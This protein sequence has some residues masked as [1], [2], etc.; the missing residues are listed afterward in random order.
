MTPAGTRW[1]R[2]TPVQASQA[3]T[4]STSDWCSAT[5]TRARRRIWT[6]VSTRRS[7]PIARDSPAGL[8][9]RLVSGVDPL[10]P[11][12]CERAVGSA[13][14]DD[15]RLER[16]A[17][18]ITEVAALEHLAREPALELLDHRRPTRSRFPL[19]AR[20]LVHLVAGL[21][22]EQ[23]GELLGIPR[24]RM[25]H[26]HVG[27]H[28]QPVR[29]VLHRQAGQEARR[30]DRDLGREADQ[31]SRPFVSASDR[32]DEQRVVE[33]AD[34]PGEV[35]IERFHRADAT[36]YETFTSGGRPNRS[37]RS[38]P[39]KRVIIE[40]RSPSSVSTKTPRGRALRSP[41]PWM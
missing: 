31:A 14:V 15:G 5:P 29:A 18:V 30:M 41:A 13:Q 23:D 12:K 11:A 33:L 40:I 9:S 10:A 35:A 16:E 28:S 26:E 8:V 6:L 25:N 27:I 37:G 3:T 7:S 19:A 20:E 4:S 34:Q 17:D 2:S 36:A 39:S 1:G 24:D 38:A 22:A 32:D 21:A